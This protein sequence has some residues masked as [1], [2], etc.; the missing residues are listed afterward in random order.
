VDD[1]VTIAIQIN[2]KTRTTIQLAKDIAKEAAE[3]KVMELQTVRDA[4]K[5]KEIKKI[6]VVPNRIVN[7][8]AS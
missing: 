8:V 7:V 1:E 4:L 5:D 6:I 3:A 2:G